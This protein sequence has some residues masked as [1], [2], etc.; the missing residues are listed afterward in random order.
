M[1][2]NTNSRNERFWG[3]SR[4]P[5]VQ[6]IVSALVTLVV[7]LIAMSTGVGAKINVTEA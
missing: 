1:E 3:F 4:N 7:V 5:A 2:K 6:A